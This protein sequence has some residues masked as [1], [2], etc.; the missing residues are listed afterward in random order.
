MP[1]TKIGPNIPKAVIEELARQQPYKKGKAE[2]LVAE[3]KILP[4]P[5]A[6]RGLQEKKVI[7]AEDSLWQK[8]KKA[9]YASDLYKELFPPERLCDKVHGAKLYIQSKDF[10]ALSS[11]DKV[12]YVKNVIK[13]AEE[14]AEKIDFTWGDIKRGEVGDFAFLQFS[15]CCLEKNEKGLLEHLS[16]MGFYGTK[17]MENYEMIEKQ[18]QPKYCRQAV[19]KKI[20]NFKEALLEIRGRLFGR[21]FDKNREYIQRTLQDIASFEGVLPEAYRSY[22]ESLRDCQKQLGLFQKLVRENSLGKKFPEIRKMLE[23]F[24]KGSAPLRSHIWPTILDELYKK[25]G[26]KIFSDFIK[27]TFDQEQKSG[28]AGSVFGRH[29]LSSFLYEHFL[30][31]HVFDKFQMKK[32]EFLPKD[33]SP[34]ETARCLDVVLEKCTA[35]LQAAPSPEMSECRTLTRY[36]RSKEKEADALLGNLTFCRALHQRVFEFV[37]DPKTGKGLDI[38]ELYTQLDAL[39]AVPPKGERGALDRAEKIKVLLSVAAEK[40]K[41]EDKKLPNPQPP[42]AAAHLRRPLPPRPQVVP[43]SGKPKSPVKKK[44]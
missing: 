1:E 22:P 9:F 27:D 31:F 41:I 3:M 17:P 5:V 19:L 42:S 10:Q 32:E 37:M 38:R 15:L 39:A 7:L 40:Q 8:I 14:W 16:R 44:M 18:L 13:E 2:K 4:P 35:F 20:E 28:Q 30:R 12:H 36:I 34:Q 25:M 26:P 43:S 6:Q 11:K 23:E 29:Q 24:Q 21:T 33:D